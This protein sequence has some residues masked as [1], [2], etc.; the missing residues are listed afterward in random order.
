MRP[1]LKSAT[2]MRSQ[3][4]NRIG[5]D[6]IRLSDR[7]Q[8]MSSHTP[9]PNIVRPI[10]PWYC[11]SFASFSCAPGPPLDTKRDDIARIPPQTPITVE[12]TAQIMSDLLLDGGLRNPHSDTQLHEIIRRGLQLAWQSGARS[13]KVL[14]W[15]TTP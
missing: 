1:T 12:M 13:G 3:K 7:T 11:A 2:A 8:S 4:T 9:Q 14:P 6:P 10:Q 5:C 15:A